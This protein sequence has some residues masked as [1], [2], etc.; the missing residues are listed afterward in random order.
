MHLRKGEGVP[1][2]PW[3]ILTSEEAEKGITRKLPAIEGS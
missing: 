3:D 1:L 2:I